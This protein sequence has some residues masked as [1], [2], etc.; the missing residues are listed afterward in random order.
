MLV[1]TRSRFRTYRKSWLIP[2]QTIRRATVPASQREEGKYLTIR[3]IPRFAPINTNQYTRCLLSLPLLLLL[4]VFVSASF[5][6]SYHHPQHASSDL[7]HRKEHRARTR[8]LDSPRR[9]RRRS[10]TRKKKE[11]GAVHPSIQTDR[12]TDRYRYTDRHGHPQ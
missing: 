8:T 3:S 6:F 10:G 12:Q 7:F 4:L 9:Q 5:C 2:G 1:R 11:R